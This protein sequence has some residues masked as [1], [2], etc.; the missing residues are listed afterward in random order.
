MENVD[1]REG[2]GEV[3][4]E[5]MTAEQQKDKEEVE[6]EKQDEMGDMM[7]GK[8][9]DDDEVLEDENEQEGLEGD[10]QDGVEEEVNFVACSWCYRCL[11]SPLGRQLGW[12]C[13]NVNIPSFILYLILIL[14]N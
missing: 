4:E 10:Q 9:L 14:F 3:P 6:E 7:A 2:T 12:I 8:K 1:E 5:E 11:Y 13:A